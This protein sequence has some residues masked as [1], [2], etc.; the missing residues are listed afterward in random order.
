MIDKK[1]AKKIDDYAKK[2]K[3]EAISIRR[4]L[5]QIPEIGEDLPK[6]RRF[7]LNE[8]NK[9]DV[10][11]S[12]NVGNN[13]IVALLKGGQEGKTVAYRAD[14]D[15]LPILEGNDFQFK[16][17]H[18]GKMHACGHDGHVTI[19]LSILKVL[20]FIKDE[21]KGNIKFVFQP[22]EETVGG[23][24]NM[25]NDG[26]LQNP[27]VEY[28]LGSH[29]WP[30]IESGQF[31]LRKGPIMAGADIFEIFIQGKG[32]HGA[33]PHK[34]INPIV[35]G[36]KIINEIEAIKNYFVNSNENAVV[37]IG[38]LNSGDVHNVIPHNATILGT[39]RFFSKD[40]QDIIIEKLQKIIDN[41]SDIYGAECTLKYTKRFPATINN[42]DVISNIEHILTS[43][44][45]EGNIFKI[46]EPSMGAED[47]SFY[48]QE[49]PGS[50]IF[51]GTK[52]EEKEIVN[53]IH[54]P[55][56][57]IDEDI[58]EKAT[59]ILCKLLLE[60]LEK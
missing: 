44:G 8:L 51:L 19:A 20:S 9:Y 24:L 50:F 54:H 46:D 15:A 57:N 38:A 27:K 59:S 49:I 32:G 10:E 14:M 21:I 16:S 33:M 22:A 60:F 47:F 2:I 42:S 35:V 29:I 53:E 34:A 31:G 52:N 5:H 36:C 12:E 28:I 40:T 37:T 39:V 4:E 23:A 48:L 11:V 30:S 6:T 7:I 55:R 56:F 45:M 26:V 41:I 3:D 17:K 43:Y 18:K 58:F 1:L 25:I 13:G